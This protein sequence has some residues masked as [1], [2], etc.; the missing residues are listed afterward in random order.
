ML[1][2]D[3]GIGY[4]VTFVALVTLNA[5]NA[6]NALRSAHAAEVIDGTVCERYDQFIRRI[7][8]HIG[9]GFFF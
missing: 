1:S 7:E 6:L 9:N 4:A 5:L 3:I 2:G 8:L